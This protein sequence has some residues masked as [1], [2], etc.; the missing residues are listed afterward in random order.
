MS[1]DPSPM[2]AVVQN[3]IVLALVLACAAYVGWQLLKTI[4]AGNGKAGACCSKG[5]GSGDS[6]PAVSTGPREQFISADLL[7]RRR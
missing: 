4:R 5:C 6:T 2:N 3:L 7:R 1:Y